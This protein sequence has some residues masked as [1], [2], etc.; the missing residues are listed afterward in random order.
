MPVDGVITSV[1]S[2]GFPPFTPGFA[3]IT[4]FQALNQKSRMGPAAVE[5]KS[6][7]KRSTRSPYL[8]CTRSTGRHSSWMEN[9]A[10]FG[11]T[12]FW[13]PVGPLSTAS[14]SNP[15]GGGTNGPLNVRNFVFVKGNGGTGLP[16]WHEVGAGTLTGFVSSK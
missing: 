12:A 8:T 13:T 3:H 5:G 15:A 9:A 4:L 11:D 6:N 2:M 7:W 14:H 16:G 10:N 1:S